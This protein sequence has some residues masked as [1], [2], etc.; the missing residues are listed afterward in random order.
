M[1]NSRKRN[2]KKIQ[3][4]IITV[5]I[6]AGAAAAGG[7]YLWNQAMRTES[8]DSGGK[9]NG[10][11]EASNDNV[12]EYNGQTYTYNDHLSNYLFMGI[13]ATDEVSTY[14]SQQDAGQADTIFLVSM[15]RVTE[16]IQVLL[17][18]RDTMTE[19][20][21]FNPSGESL[22]T[23][24][25]H[26]N[27]QYAYGD[28]K[29]KSCDLMETAVSGLLDGI[30]IHGCCAVNMDGISVIVDLVGGVEITVPD[31]SLEEVS[32]EFQEGS[33]ITLTG[34]KAEQFVRFRDTSKSGSSLV[35][36]ERQKTF[37]RALLQRVQEE[38]SED[39]GFITEMYNAIQP[40]MVTSLGTDIF[41]K[42]VTSADG[43]TVEV[44]TVPGEMTHPGNFD[45]YH[46]NKD[47]FRKLLVEMYYK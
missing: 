4:I 22:G 45:E 21:V 34:E 36:Q 47:E 18:P 26:I 16:E 24:E 19:I 40:Y 46:I 8:M 29:E 28:G 13:D 23:T 12:I 7:L 1:R 3:S 6:I 35:R 2:R 17:I 42:L 14:K 5:L 9:A 32:P 38:V 11:S 20:G 43:N 10:S 33:V 31:A 30:P 41:A 25:D 39:A 27:L 37:M 15:D 44:E